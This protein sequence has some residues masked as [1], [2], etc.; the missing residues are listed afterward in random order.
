[1]SVKT[2]TIVHVPTLELIKVDGRN[3][4]DF[5][6]ASVLRVTSSE[7]LSAE[8]RARLQQIVGYAWASVIRGRTSLGEGRV[9]L[10]DDSVTFL[11][12]SFRLTNRRTDTALVWSEF[13]QAVTT[14]VVTGTP[15]RTSNR[16][17]VGTKGTRLVEPVFA[18]SE[19]TLS[20]WVDATVEVPRTYQIDLST[21]DAASAHNL[22]SLL[23]SVGVTPKHV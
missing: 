10:E 17:G 11:S 12:A 7:Y 14:Y 21:L 16:A 1:M 19:V 9:L 20:F 22:L 13:V 15:L 18:H 8:Q 2:R 3:A 4:V 6:S 23:T 5:D